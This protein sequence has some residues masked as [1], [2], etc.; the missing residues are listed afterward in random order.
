MLIGK[1]IAN[2]IE[3]RFSPR[4]I[5]YAAEV[6]AVPGVDK[7]NLLLLLTGGSIGQQRL[8][9]LAE[10]LGVTVDAIRTLAQKSLDHPELIQNPRKML[11]ALNKIT[12]INKYFISSTDKT[13][14]QIIK[15]L[16]NDSNI[17]L[18]DHFI[19]NG[20]FHIRKTS[21]N[22]VPLRQVN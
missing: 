13:Q 19:G 3:I 14:K 15:L 2:L 4:S 17:S 8:E 22:A 21:K 6:L 1:I 7:S 5:S 11:D 9:A 16:E 12:Y 20:N 10:R 18:G